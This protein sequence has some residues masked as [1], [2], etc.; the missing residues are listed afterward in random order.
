MSEPLN[1]LIMGAAGRDFHDYLTYF[2]DS[3]RFRV[4]AFTAAQIPFIE[5]R[6]FP[7]EL[8]GPAAE[9]DIPIHD[10]DEL[11]RLIRELDVDFVFLAY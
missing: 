10:E 8:A 2:R 1:C 7:Q 4:K 5:S 9:G 11:P 3:D 6:S